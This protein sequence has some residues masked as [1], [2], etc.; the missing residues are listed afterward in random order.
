MALRPPQHR[1]DA[2]PLYVVADDPAWN[3]DRIEKDGK[4]IDDRDRVYQEQLAAFDAACLKLPKE[5]WPPRPPAPPSL[6]DYP[7]VRYRL[8]ETRFDIEAPMKW[9]GEVVRI[10]D[11]WI[12]EPTHFVLQRL[13]LDVYAR[14][15]DRFISLSVR[16]NN[17]V[18]QHW[19]ELFIECTRFGVIGTRNGDWSVQLRNGRVSDETIRQ[20]IDISGGWGM[21]TELGLAVWRLSQPLSLQEKKA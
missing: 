4:L 12:A 15:A 11:W 10:S 17:E 13:P 1:I 14:I 18:D 19:N 5:E 21:V 8:G 2:T 9:E 16:K 7:V 20:M 6:G 3:N